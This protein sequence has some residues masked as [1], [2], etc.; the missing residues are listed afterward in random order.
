M[1]RLV[2]GADDPGAVGGADDPGAVGGADDPG[3]V[4]GADDPGEVVADD[5]A[6]VV[7]DDPA[8][9]VA[10]PLAGAAEVLGAGVPLAMIEQGPGAVC[11]AF[12]TAAHPASTNTTPASGAV[13][14]PG[15]GI[16]IR[17]R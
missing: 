14:L 6:E 5:P 10:E 2:G 1:F 12:W 3:A 9:V 11:G 13:T 15:D 8:E 17:R 7:A 16:R 4:G